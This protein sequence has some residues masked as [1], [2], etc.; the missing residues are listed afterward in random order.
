[1]EPPVRGMGPARSSGLVAV[2]FVGGGVAAS[3]A[4]H[5]G[6]DSLARFAAASLGPVSAVAALGLQAYFLLGPA[7]A[8]SQPV[9]V[10][11]LDQYFG[12][13]RNPCSSMNPTMD[14]P[15]SQALQTCPCLSG[16][17]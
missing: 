17:C 5:A 4:R 1:V 15:Y 3:L 10:R 7:F 14:P 11:D 12:Q 13:R 6:V 16:S 2:A 8:A 9:A